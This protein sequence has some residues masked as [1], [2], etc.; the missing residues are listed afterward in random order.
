[1]AFYDKADDGTF[2]GEICDPLTVYWNGRSLLVDVALVQ[3]T[4]G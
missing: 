4:A 1:M 3:H 2:V